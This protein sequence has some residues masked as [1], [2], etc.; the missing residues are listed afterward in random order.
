MINQSF[1]HSLYLDSVAHKLGDAE[2]N[3]W[4][5]VFILFFGSYFYKF[6]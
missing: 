3:G 5:M 2:K 6:S 1:K 4:H